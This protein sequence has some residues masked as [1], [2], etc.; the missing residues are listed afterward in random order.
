MNVLR[1]N[2]IQ[3]TDDRERA[4]RAVGI[5]ICTFA[6]GACECSNR[7]H[8]CARVEREASAVIDALKASGIAP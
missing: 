5:R 1:T 3:L 2:D 6:N 7:R 4:L 8:I